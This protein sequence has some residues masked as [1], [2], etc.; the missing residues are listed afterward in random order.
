MNFYPKRNLFL[1]IVL[2]AFSVTIFLK[3]FVFQYHYTYLR[4]SLLFLSSYTPVASS[5]QMIIQ[6]CTV[7]LSTPQSHF[8]HLHYRFAILSIVLPVFLYPDA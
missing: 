4:L 1:V 6:Y 8:S 2:W 3:Y 7:P 5:A